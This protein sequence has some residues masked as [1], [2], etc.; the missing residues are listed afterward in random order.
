MTPDDR[1]LAREALLHKKLS[2]DQVTAIQKDC[3][4]SGSSFAQAALRRGLLAQED[5]DTLLGASAPP[6]PAIFSRLL[7]ATLAILVLL[8]VA[9][10]VRLVRWYEKDRELAEL[11]IRSNA[12]AERQAQE[13]RRAWER[14]QLQKA[15]S[16][17]KATLEKARGLMKFAEERLREAPG[18][19]QLNLQLVEATGLFNSYLNAHPDDAD[20][21]VER[22]RTYE[23]R[24]A[25]ERALADLDRAIELR[26]DLA[27]K[28]DGKLQELRLQVARPKK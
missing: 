20:I 21:L 8:V 18:E 24:R 16:E 2:I 25:L 7:V 15:E 3:E 26:K 22:S 5:V 14:E 27:P 28:L 19:P 17:S 13:A 4:A 6:A 1:S 9:G 11:S 23:L 10:I 12:A